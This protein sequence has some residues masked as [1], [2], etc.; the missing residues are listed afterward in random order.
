MP[1]MSVNCTVDGK[2]KTFNTISEFFDYVDKYQNAKI[3]DLGSEEAWQQIMQYITGVN[4]KSGYGQ[5]IVNKTTAGNAVSINE[6][7]G[8]SYSILHLFNE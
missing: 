6:L 1:T 3:I 7:S 8:E 2:S 5:S 4:I